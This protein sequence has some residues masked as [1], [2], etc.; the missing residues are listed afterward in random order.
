MSKE[1][2]TTLAQWLDDAIESGEAC[3]YIR[4]RLICK[5]NIYN[6]GLNKDFLYIYGNHYIQDVNTED[7]I[8]FNIDII[9]NQNVLP[10]LPKT[11][12]ESVRY[13][14]PHW[15]FLG[16]GR[17]ETRQDYQCSEC[18]HIANAQYPYCICG[19]CMCGK[20]IH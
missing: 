6:I 13:N 16:D 15:I 9:E 8:H 1:K 11:P 2:L 4:G 19:A 14:G 17:P 3:I 12:I 20:P 10:C 5:D 18:G 7:N